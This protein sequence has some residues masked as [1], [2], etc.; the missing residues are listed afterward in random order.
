MKARAV[1]ASYLACMDTTEEMLAKLRHLG[2]RWKA[3]VLPP[4]FPQEDSDKETEGLAH[5]RMILEL[6]DSFLYR[7]HRVYF[8]WSEVTGHEI[9]L[10]DEECIRLARE[11]PYSYP[12][13]RAVFPKAD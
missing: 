5:A 3:A 7:P 2:S 9:A 4:I 12:Y 1:S 11:R 8:Y 13:L 6:A 10:T